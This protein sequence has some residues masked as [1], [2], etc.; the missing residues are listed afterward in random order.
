[1]G[2]D[3]MRHLALDRPN[4]SKLLEADMLMPWLVVSP[5]YGVVDPI[6]DGQGPVEYGSDVCFVEAENA[7]EAMV[8]GVHEF[9]RMKAPYLTRLDE[10]PFSGLTVIPQRCQAHGVTNIVWTRDHFECS[11]C[12]ASFDTVAMKGW[13]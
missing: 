12:E 10:N 5:E 4:W 9:R 13:S 1:M 7:R 2:A 6:V 3:T 8:L 11:A